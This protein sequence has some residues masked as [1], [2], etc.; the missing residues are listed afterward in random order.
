GMPRH[1]VDEVLE[2]RVR[3]THPTP[4]Q[5]DPS[6]LGELCA[7]E[8]SVQRVDAD[9]GTVIDVHEVEQRALERRGHDADPSTFSYTRTTQSRVWS[10]SPALR[11]TRSLYAERV[12]ST[13]D[14]FEPPRP[15]A[16]AR[17]CAR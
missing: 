14:A 5:I 7:A 1:G 6:A 12:R 13:R 4:P 10:A 2:Q 16:G 15:A 8:R 9:L 3:A 17:R 11:G